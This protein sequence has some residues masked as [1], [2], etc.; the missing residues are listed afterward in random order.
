MSPEAAW[1]EM[2]AGCRQA[3]NGHKQMKES[4]FTFKLVVYYFDS[5]M[6]TCPVK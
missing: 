6:I 4:C 5:V 1:T 2:K 3:G